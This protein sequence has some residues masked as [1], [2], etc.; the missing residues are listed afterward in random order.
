MTVFA[1]LQHVF[2][3]IVLIIYHRN[4][5]VNINKQI[6]VCMPYVWGVQQVLFR[7]PRATE[8]PMTEGHCLLL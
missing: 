5:N 7:G 3:F 6:Y 2:V 4:V 1:E 8:G